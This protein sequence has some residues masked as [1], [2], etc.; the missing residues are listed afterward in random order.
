MRIL[1][2]KCQNKRYIIKSRLSSKTLLN[3][4]YCAQTN[5][6]KLIFVSLKQK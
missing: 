1:R 3:N 6:L 4:C 2:L 5:E